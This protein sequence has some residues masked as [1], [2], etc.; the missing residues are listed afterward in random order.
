M[1]E[2]YV[3]APDFVGNLGYRQHAIKIN[4]KQIYAL[5]EKFSKEGSALPS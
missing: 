5:C 2:K 3:A 1:S 4:P